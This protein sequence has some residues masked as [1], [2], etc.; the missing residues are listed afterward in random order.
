MPV[1]IAQIVK[2]PTLQFVY[3][4]RLVLFSCLK[5]FNFKPKPFSKTLKNV[6]TNT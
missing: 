5:Q 4:D 2:I 3:H 1:Y 6:G